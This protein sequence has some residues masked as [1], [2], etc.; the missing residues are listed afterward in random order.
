MDSE[1]LLDETKKALALPYRE[2]SVRLKALGFQAINAYKSASEPILEDI[3]RYMD[4]LRIVTQMPHAPSSYPMWLSKMTV[5]Y[6]QLN[7]CENP[8][9]LLKKSASI[10]LES[11]TVSF[12]DRS[13]EV[14]P[15]HI[16][17]TE[18][19][20]IKLVNTGKCYFFSTGSDGEAKLQIRMIDSPEP[21][22]SVK[23]YKSVVS[24]SPCVIL[25]FPTGRLVI[26]DGLIIKGI[27][28]PL[29]FEIT[30]GHY[31]AQVYLCRFRGYLFYYYIVLAKTDAEAVNQEHDIVSLNQL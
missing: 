9:V 6:L 4:I 29:E 5:S 13:S 2:R 7:G 21:V 8:K 19:E 22:L 26:D 18:K 20:Y 25:N 15:D 3:K 27:A 1:F 16:T 14:S 10:L 11:G 17:A 23:E 28:S 24:T 31:K 30:P 12:G